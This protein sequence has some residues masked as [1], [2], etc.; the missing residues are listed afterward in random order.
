MLLSLTN[1]LSHYL[2]PITSTDEFYWSSSLQTELQTSRFTVV[3]MA[4]LNSLDGSRSVVDISG[5]S[6]SEWGMSPYPELNC[7]WFVEQAMILITRNEPK[8]SPKR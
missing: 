7:F 1:M 2:Y 3:Q 5:M 8:L 6:L 4:A